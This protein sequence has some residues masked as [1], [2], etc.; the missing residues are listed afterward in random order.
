VT[1]PS[2]LLNNAIVIDNMIYLKYN[3]PV[4]ENSEL[5]SSDD[6]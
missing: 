4:N 6:P 5:L 2:I 3:I 1:A